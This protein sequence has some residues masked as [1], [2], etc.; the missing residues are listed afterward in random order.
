[1]AVRH[2]PRHP[3]AILREDVLPA[4]GLSI[5]EAARQLGV[6][7]VT[8]GLRGTLISRLMSQH[9]AVVSEMVVEHEGMCD[10]PVLQRY[11]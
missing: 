11:R 8:S 5:T 3:G 7:R 2:N 6:S 10:M 4:L 9:E 1:M